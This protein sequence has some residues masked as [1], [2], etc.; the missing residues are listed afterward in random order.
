MAL[1][2]YSGNEPQY[3]G[4]PASAAVWLDVGGSGVPTSLQFIFVL[5]GNSALTG[6]KVNQTLQII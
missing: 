5:D 3:N 1:I 4:A 2:A 6:V